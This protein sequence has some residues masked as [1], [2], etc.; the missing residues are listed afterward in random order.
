MVDH[1]RRYAVAAVDQTPLFYE[2]WAPLRPDDLSSAASDAAT[3]AAVHDATEPSPA[4]RAV[5][6]LL[7][8]GIGCD[9][10]VWRYLRPDLTDRVVAHGHYR[11][12]GR[13]RE[14]SDGDR[15]TIAD[16]ADDQIAILDDAGLER[17]VII[18]HSMGVQVAL[19]TMRRHRDRVAGLVLVCGAP[20]HP[21]RT[22]RGAATLEQV[23]PRVSAVVDSVPQVFQRLARLALPTRLAY[24]VASWLE[25]Q[26]DKVSPADFMPYLHGMSRIDPRLFVR[27]L[28][29]AGQHSADDFLGAV[30][31]PT[32]VFGATEDGF[33]PMD[34][35]RQMAAH[36]PGAV[37]VEVEHGSHTAPLEH[38]GIFLRRIR[39]FL[40]A[41]FADQSLSSRNYSSSH[42]DPAEPEG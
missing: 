13:S 12:H 14:P 15:V 2:V 25:I 18:G 17:V 40:H 33:T 8:D 4:Q 36:I 16:L 31:V 1:R 21:L 24:E 6:V 41:N 19:E 29:A 30:D 23:L 34:R 10:Y 7:C 28:A 22:F 3:T 37:L 20:S 26:R 39:D 35:S 9:G 11:G 42:V 5:P 27:M 38:P 32:L